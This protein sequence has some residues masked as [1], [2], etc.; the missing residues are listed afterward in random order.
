MNRNAPYIVEEQAVATKQLV[1]RS[2]REIAQVLMVNRVELAVVYQ[3]PD[4]RE[5][6]DGH[7]FGCQQPGN[8]RHEAVRVGNVRKNVVRVNDISRIAARGESVRQ[9]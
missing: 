1:Y 7:A 9:R 5:L 8:A 6:Q 2:D 4:I 3:V